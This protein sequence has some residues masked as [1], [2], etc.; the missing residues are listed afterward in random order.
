MVVVKTVER[1]SILIALGLLYLNLFLVGLV[2][3]LMVVEQL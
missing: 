1:V 3:V 2:V